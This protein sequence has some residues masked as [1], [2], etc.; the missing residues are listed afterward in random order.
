[1][2][3]LTGVLG[4]IK[5]PVNDSELTVDTLDHIQWRN[6]IA[7]LGKRAT[8]T[9]A[10]TYETEMMGVLAGSQYQD[11]INVERTEL[12]R[13]LAEASSLWVQLEETMGAL[14]RGIV[15]LQYMIGPEIN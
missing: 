4:M 10:D 6:V 2:S 12:I 1:M 15:S 13:N 9:L 11:Q 7:T 8:A 3:S 14:E 5:L